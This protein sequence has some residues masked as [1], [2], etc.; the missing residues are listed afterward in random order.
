MLVFVLRYFPNFPYYAVVNPKEVS[1]DEEVQKWTAADPLVDGHVYL[2]CLP[3]PLLGGPKIL[4]EDYKNWD[5]TKPLLILHGDADQVTNCP[6]SRQLVEKTKAS[7]KEHKEWP[8]Q[9]H[10]VWHEKGDVKVDFI[11]YIIQWVLEG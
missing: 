4:A 2:K 8:G 11:N 9:F 7:D 10:E 6:G 5:E 3:G 1:H